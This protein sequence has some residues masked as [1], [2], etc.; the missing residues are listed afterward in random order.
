MVKT[1]EHHLLWNQKSRCPLKLVCNI[2]Y[3]S[4][5]KFVQMMTLGW[6]WPILRG[7]VKFGPLCFC[8]GKGKNNWFFFSETI[9]VFDIQIREY[10]KL[11]E[12]QRSRSF[13]DL[14]PNHLRFIFFKLLF[15][16]NHSAEFCQIVCGVSLAWGNESKLFRSHDQDGHHAHIW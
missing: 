13:I 1:S 3:A 15:L 8:I 9:V 4:A 11:Y 14:G 2:V 7:K 12:Y 5:T 10:M 6:P 16:N